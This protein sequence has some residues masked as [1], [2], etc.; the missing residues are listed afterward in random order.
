MSVC[1]RVSE[2]ESEQVL[3]VFLL[4]TSYQAREWNVVYSLPRD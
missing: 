1:E 4:V 3:C 2:C